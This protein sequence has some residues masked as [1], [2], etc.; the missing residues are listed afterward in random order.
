MLEKKCPRCRRKV[1]RKYDFCPYCGFSLK[2][3]KKEDWGMLGENDFDF[4]NEN[5]L[6]LGRSNFFGINI[7]RMFNN[8]IRMLE[9]EM[10]RE[11]KNFKTDSEESPLKTNLQIFINGKKIDLNNLNSDSLNTRNLK[12]TKKS[13]AKP[14]IKIDFPEFSKQKIKEFSK[15][16]KQE[17]ETK[18]RRLSD[19]IIYEINLPGIKSKK[20][21]SIKKLEKS[22]EI[23]AVSK[24]T[25]YYKIIK[26]DLPVISYKFA[27]ELLI[28][29]FDNK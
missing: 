19:K 28:L 12:K 23:K 25:A 11:M 29:E 27:K 24:N 9:K 2:Q 22:I 20:D 5:T 7:N 4:F 6:G 3:K 16:L 8:A 15:L 26:I 17:P 21:I 18:I 10:Q 1:K 14:R 13:S